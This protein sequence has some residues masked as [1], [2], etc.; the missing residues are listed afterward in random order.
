MKKFIALFFPVFLLGGCIAP[1]FQFS[2][3]AVR[4]GNMSMKEISQEFR[5]LGQTTENPGP[6]PVGH[7]EVK[8][9]LIALQDIA[10]LSKEQQE[11]AHALVWSGKNFYRD[12]SRP[13]DTSYDN[14]TFWLVNRFNGVF[15]YIE[16]LEGGGAG[17]VYIDSESW[18]GDG[19]PVIAVDYGVMTPLMGFMRNE[20]RVSDKDNGVPGTRTYLGMMWLEIN[21]QKIPFAY[22]IPD[23][24]ATYI[25]H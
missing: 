4:L 13:C 19:Q 17:R 9:G 15:S 16:N 2:P 1:E 23:Q 8:A 12:E 21:G 25:C 7:A 14:S 3:E 22:F 20:M 24:V 5:R 11:L 6:I 10:G 18:I